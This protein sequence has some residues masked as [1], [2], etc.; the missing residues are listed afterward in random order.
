[1]KSFSQDIVKKFGLFKAGDQN[2]VGKFFLKLGISA[3]MMTTFA[4]IVGL[5]SVYFLFS[6]HLSFII[7]AVVHLLAD[8]LDGLIAK[9]SQPTKFG[10]YFDLISDRTIAFLVLL[11]IALH[12][13]DYY[14]FIILGL[15]VLT[16]SIHFFSKLES[17]VIF[18]RTGTLIGAAIYVLYEPLLTIGYLLAG[19]FIVYSLALQLEYFVK[20][21]F[22]KR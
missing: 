12:L 5:V 4:L 8:G 14:F 18:I 1:M 13:Q 10:Q 17:P 2:K 3:N 21:M 19:I 6:N 16:Q 15:Y 22:A 20:K 9:A 7:L 11:K